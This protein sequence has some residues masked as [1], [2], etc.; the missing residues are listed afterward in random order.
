MIRWPEPGDRPVH[1]I[2]RIV[3]QTGDRRRPQPAREEVI[4]PL[5]EGR[6]AVEE[7]LIVA[8]SGAL[9]VGPQ[10]VSH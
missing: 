10:I 6:S 5:I 2:A 1:L 8:A 9:T 4:D 7:I 3:T